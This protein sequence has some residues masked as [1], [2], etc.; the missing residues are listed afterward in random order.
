MFGSILGSLAGSALSSFL[1]S[2]AADKNRDFQAGMSNTAYQRATKDMIA[3][4]LNPGLAYSQGGASVPSGAVANVGDFNIADDVSKLSNASSTAKMAETQLQRAQ[5]DVGL[6][7]A[8]TMSE[9]ANAKLMAL[10]AKNAEDLGFDPQKGN[11]ATNAAQGIKSLGSN[12]TDFKDRKFSPPSS[13]KE[14]LDR[15]H[16]IFQ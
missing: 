11:L 14:L 15:L 16:S 7:R 9:Y 4:G 2:R 6:T 1:G 10:A 5:A 3:A 8:Q 13:A 12:L